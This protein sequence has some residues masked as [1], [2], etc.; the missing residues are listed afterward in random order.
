MLLP[1][2]QVTFPQ[3]FLLKSATKGIVRSVTSWKSLKEKITL[4]A[5]HLKLSTICFDFGALV[6]NDHM[7]D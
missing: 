7:Q 6:Q 5:G 3:K 4:D 1:L 2:L